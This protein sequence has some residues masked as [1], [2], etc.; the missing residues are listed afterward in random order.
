MAWRWAN[1]S[2]RT[3]LFLLLSLTAGVALLLVSTGL[4]INEKWNAQKNLVGE[5]CSIADV[6]ALNSGAAMAFNDEQAAEETLNS[7]AAKPEIAAAILYDKDGDT[8]SKYNRK[9]VNA[10]LLITDLNAAYPVRQDIFKQLNEGGFVSHLSNGYIHILRPV[11]AQNVLVGSIH[12]VDDMQQ[13]RNR[14]KTYYIVV[15][16]IVVITL[17]VVLL[18]STMS[19]KIF[20]RPLLELMQSI[21]EV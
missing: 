10:E 4:M 5:L 7:L 6:V 9:G 2:I 1:L 19:Q 13:V 18:L 8:Y 21:K 14:L 16:F 20:T 3:K 12:L 15:A 17:M 11:F